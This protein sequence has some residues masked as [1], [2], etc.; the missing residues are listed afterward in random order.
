MTTMREELPE[1][2]AY[3]TVKETCQERQ[4]RWHKSVS[5]TSGICLCIFWKP[6]IG[7]LFLTSRTILVGVMGQ[8]I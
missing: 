1:V 2:A 5:W 7:A 8:N 6:Q 4:V 3:S